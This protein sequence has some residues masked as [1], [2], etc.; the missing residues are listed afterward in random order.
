MHYVTKVDG[1]ITGGPY[2]LTDDRTA[3]PNTAWKAEQLA[4]HGFELVADPVAEPT[5]EELIVK[6][7]R[8]IA[9]AALKVDGILDSDAKITPAGKTIL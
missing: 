9:V 8:E 4:I 6:K 7:S 1:Q 2:P 5:V 3:S